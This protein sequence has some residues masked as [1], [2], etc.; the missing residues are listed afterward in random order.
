MNCDI[1]LSACWFYCHTAYGSV[2]GLVCA[3]LSRLCECVCVFVDVPWDVWHSACVL[4]ILGALEQ[5]AVRGEEVCGSMSLWCF[6]AQLR[7]GH[8]CSSL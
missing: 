4:G 6:I 2:Y 8:P 1:K 7:C 3:S 5:I